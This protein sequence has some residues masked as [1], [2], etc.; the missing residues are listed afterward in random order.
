MQK[1]IANTRPVL[2][3]NS[4]LKC[5]AL[6]SVSLFSIGITANAQV[7]INEG[8]NKNYL[9]LADEDDEYQ[10]WVELY[11]SGNEA[12]NLFG[13]GLSDQLE[14][15]SQWIFPSV[16]LEPG[17]FLL[18]FCSGKD[19]KPIGPFQEVL[20]LASYTPVAGWNS[21]PL[22][23]AYDWDGLSSV[24]INTCSYVSTGYTL[25]ATFFQSETAY[26]S[27]LFG[28]QDGSDAVCGAAY[29]TRV[30]FRPNIR[31]NGVS[32]GAG[33]L[34]N[35]P[36]D[37]PAPFGNWYWAARHQM[38]IPANEL[39]GAGLAAG[40]ITSF[41]LNV[42]TP[43]GVI[44][45]D[46]F[47]VSMQA[48]AETEVSTAF[49]P[50]NLNA[51]LHS[52]FKLSGEGETVYLF[53]ANQNLVSDMLVNVSGLDQSTGPQPD[54]ESNSFL[55]SAPTPGASNN[56]SETF[57]EYLVAPIFSVESGIYNNAFE[58]SIANENI[59][60][61]SIHYTLYGSEPTQEDPIYNGAP[62]PIYFSTSLK[63]KVFQEGSLPSATIA[64]SYLLGVNHH[65]PI[66]C[67][68]T[69]YENLYGSSGI[70]DNWWTDWQRS[71]HA[72]YFDE[73]QQLIFA[74]PAGIQIDGGAGGSRY[75]PQHSFRLEL[76]HSVLGEN[77]IDYMAIPN[78]SERTKYSNFYFRN[79]S[80]MYQ[81]Y[82]IKDA[83]QVE[84]MAG[85]SKAYY[86]S[87]RPVTVYINGSYFG[88]YEM[89]EKVDMEFFEELEN[90]HPD[91]TDLLSVSYWY[92]GA[93]RAV[94]GSVDSFFETY[95]EFNALEATTE[96]YWQE[97]DAYFDLESYCDYIIAETWMANTD[98]PWNNIKIYRSNKT[99]FRWR[100]G[101][102]D[103]ENGMTPFGWTD[104]YTDM[105]DYVRYADQNI[106]YINVFVQSIE[107]ELFRKYFINRYADVMNTSYRYERLE[108]VANDMF[109]QTLLEMPNQYQRWGD[110][111][112]IAGQMQWYVNNHNSFLDAL[113]Q[114]TE[115]VRNHIEFNFEM[116]DQV[117]V[118]LDVLP[119]G[120]GKIKI[121][122][123][124]PDSLPWSGIYF[125]GNPVRLTA[126]PNPGYIFAYWEPN[127]VT[128]QA[129]E[130]ASIEADMSSDV[131]FTA[132]F[133]PT[134]VEGQL[135]ITEINFHSADTHD[136]GDWIECFNAGNA[137][138]DLSAWKV[139]DANPWDAY[140]WPEGSTLLPGERI[141]L[142]SEPA[143]FSQVH[144]GVSIY[145]VLE[146]N[147]SNGGE[148]ITVLNAINDTVISIAYTESLPWQPAADGHGRTLELRANSIESSLPGSW[149]AGCIGGS[150]GLAYSPC[151][152]P[153][154]ISEVNYKSSPSE[155]A[156][157]WIELYNPSA[158]SL[159]LSAWRLEDSQSDNAYTF[160][161]G[162]SIAAGGY[163]VVYNNIS[164]FTS[165]FPQVSNAAGPA[166][167]QLNSAGESLSLY[168]AN[169]ILV[170]SLVYDEALPWPSAANGG[171]Y[172]LELLDYEGIACDGS[173]WFA[174]CPEGSPGSAYTLPCP[175]ITS[176][177]SA[178]E[179]GVTIFPNP[180]SGLLH[181]TGG[182]GVLQT[183]EKAD[184][185]VY[186]ALGVQVHGSSHAAGAE[187]IRM[188]L[189][190]LSPGIYMVALKSGGQQWRWKW[191]ME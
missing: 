44:E 166:L 141:V 91:S 189:S 90:A 56:G 163:I 65:T 167:F 103:L 182:T 184:V 68:T 138:L 50:L 37:Y 54:G 191:V 59:P 63:A 173:N 128:G 111:F 88:L 70:F 96:N 27:T 174:G 169:G 87:W 124:V 34:E 129:L 4:I 188:D 140:L 161:E 83:V 135:L 30:N 43:N 14:N 164:A 155:N 75:H 156:G 119:V 152:E 6:I 11:N 15:P 180:S 109:S 40:P 99:D 102:M 21:F 187:G 120:A 127:V 60:T 57:T 5:L 8:S 39:L 20:A 89:R 160:A 116:L 79:G 146:F 38:I 114:R 69:D 46:Y 118:S 29:G 122:T 42:S 171:G 148:S 168:D 179:T 48:V 136:S 51:N 143:L 181:I 172:T 84:C 132:V 22:D 149:F 66:L 18:V 28:F 3:F 126:Y 108:A 93:L 32:I 123:V 24:L 106:P 170:Y 107:N 144:P 137:P 61:S 176:T 16:M 17:Q 153:I 25:N 74:Q 162:Q 110:P 125:H 53:D 157:D 10:D 85:E 92:G 142:A 45:Y 100:F 2:N 139:K 112:N 9:T 145:G 1:E 86:S 67:L 183:S 186:N 13:Y 113:S 177:S 78:R 104:I 31:L 77:A 73:Q 26:P 131:L 190:Y 105:I 130:E 55:F 121:S 178:E 159:N 41:A 19:R 165:Q 150:P 80:N 133:E 81:S 72:A 36:T 23:E 76:A 154:I 185:R 158:E 47:R 7:I 95:D 71:A 94:E 33:T 101:V 147:L 175:F 117:E 52:N 58:V 35:S 151:I 115:Q 97:A 82:P 98:W 49:T 134:D 64:A 62:I 12:V